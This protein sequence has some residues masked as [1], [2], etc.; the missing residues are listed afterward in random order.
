[1]TNRKTDFPA[2]GGN[3]H[4]S[5]IK[6]CCAHKTKQYTPK[7]RHNRTKTA[8]FVRHFQTA[9]VL[10]IKVLRSEADW[11]RTRNDSGLEQRNERE[12]SPRFPTRP[13]ERSNDSAP[14]GMLCLDSVFPVLVRLLPWN[15]HRLETTVTAV[16]ACAGTVTCP[17]RRSA[18]PDFFEVARPKLTTG[19]T[20][21]FTKS[22]FP[23]SYP[24]PG[25][26]RNTFGDGS[27]FKRFHNWFENRPTAW[28]TSF[29]HIFWIRSD[30]TQLLSVTFTRG[31]ISIFRGRPQSHESK[32]ECFKQQTNPKI[33]SATLPQKHIFDLDVSAL[34][35][36]LV[37]NRSD[38]FLKVA[39]L[40]VTSR[41]ACKRSRL[42]LNIA[43]PLFGRW[44]GNFKDRCCA[45]LKSCGRWFVGI[46]RRLLKTGLLRDS[47]VVSEAA[48]SPSHMPH[49]HKIVLVVTSQP[50]L[51]SLP[52]HSQHCVRYGVI[53]G[54]MKMIGDKLALRKGQAARVLLTCTRC[55]SGRGRRWKEQKRFRWCYFRREPITLRRTAA[56]RNSVL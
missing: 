1:M 19:R 16:R 42:F 47:F 17:A 40:F 54:E 10:S 9:L 15:G 52:R 12:L 53:E 43:N 4:F 23:F 5:T 30:H 36:A 20:I 28:Q 48:E 29:A 14:L 45:S 41:V 26:R 39:D 21:P 22:S 56:C 33:F 31:V 49:L 8:Q 2:P 38:G 32:G 34:T 50:A 51:Y 35:S 27:V 13:K 3:C 24:A 25:R 55:S 37:N 18:R 46:F 6:F 44:S 7:W 11:F